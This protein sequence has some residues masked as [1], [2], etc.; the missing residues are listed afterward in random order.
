[1]ELEKLRKMKEQQENIR[2]DSDSNLTDESDN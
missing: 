2:S 1:M